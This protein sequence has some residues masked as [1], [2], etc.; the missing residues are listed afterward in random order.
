MDVDECLTGTGQPG[1]CQSENTVEC[2]NSYGSYTC[3]C[4]AGFSGNRCQHDRNDGKLQ[5]NTEEESANTVLGVGWK[6][7]NSVDCG[8]LS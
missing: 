3:T 6:L 8:I 1:V 7:P 5:P 4:K 2:V